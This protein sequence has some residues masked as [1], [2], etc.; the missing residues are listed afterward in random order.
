MEQLYA[1]LYIWY[2]GCDYNTEG[3]SQAPV[4]GNLVETAPKVS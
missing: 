4:S 1:Q 2:L 3:S